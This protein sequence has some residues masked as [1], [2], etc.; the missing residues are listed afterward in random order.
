MWENNLR[1]G[2]A[3]L[4]PLNLLELVLTNALHQPSCLD[5]TMDRESG[6]GD[7]ALGGFQYRISVN[8]LQ[9]PEGIPSGPKMIPDSR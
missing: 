5:S 2:D 3:V 1:C 8:A 7:T 6:G 4:T 9:G